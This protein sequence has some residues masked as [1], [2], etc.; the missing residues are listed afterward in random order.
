MIEVMH[1]ELNISKR[2]LIRILFFLNL[3]CG[4]LFANIDPD[5]IDD[6]MYFNNKT[7]VSEIQER[8]QSVHS[9][10]DIEVTPEVIE[11]INQYTYHCRKSA[12]N[13]LEK[14]MIYFP[15][16]E[17]EIHRRGMPDDL[18]YLAVIESMLDPNATSKSGAAGLWQFV[19][20]TAKMVGL[21]VND[22][23][24]QRRSI[25]KST[26]A[27]LDY[28]ESLHDRF[29]DWNL[30]IAAYNCGPGN[31][32]KA[33][34]RSNN[35]SDFW[36]IRKHLPKE[37]QKYLPRFIA[38]MYL[39]NFYH[40]HNLY[41]SEVNNDLR[42]T[43]VFSITDKLDLNKL[44]KDL[45]IDNSIIR[46]LNPE[47]IKGY[48]PENKG[49]YTVRIPNSRVGNY[50]RI[51]EP[52]VYNK[53]LLRKAAELAKEEEMEKI[54]TLDIVKKDTVAPLE[55]IVSIIVNS[56]HSITGSKNYHIPRQ[57]R[58]RELYLRKV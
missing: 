23:I 44:A 11:R 3:F 52:S 17:N 1:K 28:L 7:T 35:S 51:Y 31:V 48:I 42:F 34:K 8:M 24:D 19:K 38:A 58:S 40:Y 9:V 30:A 56:L 29:G 21:E 41:P 33:I 36:E 6:K 55:H 26:Q 53:Y 13:I 50:Y 12:T 2:Y 39:M 32:N 5:V 20:G 16:F 15:V 18:K 57:M 46:T 10:V 54:K 27:A 14:V 37:T 43:S 45:S 22:K 4:S 25:I 47:Y 49:R